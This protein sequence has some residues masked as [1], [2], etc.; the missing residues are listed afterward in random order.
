MYA[1]PNRNQFGLLYFI[2]DSKGIMQIP[3]AMSSCHY[4]QSGCAATLILGLTN[5]IVMQNITGQM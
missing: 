1:T 3:V 2:V 4:M 5:A